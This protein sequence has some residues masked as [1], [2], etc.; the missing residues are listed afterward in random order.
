MEVPS[1]APQGTPTRPDAGGI[2]SS[3]D[4]SSLLQT[5]VDNCNALLNL[6]T[7]S[8][9]SL[10]NYHH[11]A[12]TFGRLLGALGDCVKQVRELDLGSDRTFR[13][14]VES[15][16]EY[17]LHTIDAF[18]DIISACSPSILPLAQRTD[19]F[20]CLLDR[21]ETRLHLGRVS[22]RVRKECGRKDT[23]SSQEFGC[24]LSYFWGHSFGSKTEATAAEVKR[25]LLNWLDDQTLRASLQRAS[26]LELT[27]PSQKEEFLSS[28][29]VILSGDIY[30][31]ERVF[32]IAFAD[33]L[34][35]I[36][37]QRDASALLFRAITEAR[38]HFVEECMYSS[39]Y[40][41]SDD[42]AFGPDSPYPL[43]HRAEA[44]KPGDGQ[45]ARYDSPVVIY[46][47]SKAADPTAFPCRVLPELQREMNPESSAVHTFYRYSDSSAP[48]AES[49]LTYLR[50]LKE[51]E[52]S[53]GSVQPVDDTGTQP[54]SRGNR[55]SHLEIGKE[56]DTAVNGI[57]ENAPL[58]R[59]A[60][61]AV[62]TAFTPNIYLVEQL[63]FFQPSILASMG[64]GID[65]LPVPPLGVELVTLAALAVHSFIASTSS[66]MQEL[67]DSGS[68]SPEILAKASVVIATGKGLA[69]GLFGMPAKMA[70]QGTASI[71][72]TTG[73]SNGKG[74][75]SPLQSE[76]PSS[77][78]LDSRW[79]GVEKFTR[80][81]LLRSI[82]ELSTRPEG[83]SIPGSDLRPQGAGPKT[84]KKRPAAVDIYIQTATQSGV[85][86]TP[87]S[88]ARF[89]GAFLPSDGRARDVS[90]TALKTANASHAVVSRYIEREAKRRVLQE[91][92]Q[93]TGA[94]SRSA[95]MKLIRYVKNFS[96]T[97]VAQCTT[98]LKAMNPLFAEK[99][100]E[101]AA[102]A[103]FQAVEVP[104]G[105]EF[106]TSAE[107][108][109]GGPGGT[110]DRRGGESQ[111]DGLLHL[112]TLQSKLV[113]LYCNAAFLCYS[114]TDVKLSEF[115]GAVCPMGGFSCRLAI[116]MLSNAQQQWEA[117]DPFGGA[118]FQG[119]IDALADLVAAK[120]GHGSP[121]LD[122]ALACR[123]LPL[124]PQEDVRAAGRG[125]KT[126]RSWDRYADKQTN[127]LYGLK[128]GPHGLDERG[129]P[130]YYLPGKR[131]GLTQRH[132]RYLYHFAG[133]LP[134]RFYALPL[135]TVCSS[136]SASVLAALQGVLSV[137]RFIPF[138]RS[139]VAEIA[140]YAAL[141]VMGAPA[142]LSSLLALSE[143]RAM[144]ASQGKGQTGAW[145]GSGLVYT[146][147][148]EQLAR[149]AIQSAPVGGSG[150]IPGASPDATP[151][152][153]PPAVLMQA[154]FRVAVVGT[155]GAGATTLCRFLTLAPLLTSA[156]PLAAAA[157]DPNP[158]SLPA[159]LYSQPGV[160]RTPWTLPAPQET[161]QANGT[162]RRPGQAGQA[163]ST[164]R[165]SIGSWVSFDNDRPSPRREKVTGGSQG[166][167]TGPGREGDDRTEE[168]AKKDPRKGDEAMLNLMGRIVSA[169]TESGGA[170]SQ[171]QHAQTYADRGILSS[172]PLLPD[173]ELP[174]ITP[175]F[176]DIRR[177]REVFEL[178]RNG[179]VVWDSNGLNSD[180]LLAEGDTA[181]P[182]SDLLSL[183][184]QGVAT[185]AA[186][187]TG[188]AVSMH[189]AVNPQKLLSVYGPAAPLCSSI[190]VN[191]LG[192]E[193][194]PGNIPQLTEFPPMRCIDDISNFPKSLYAAIGV[195]MEAAARGLTGAG[196]K[197]LH[198]PTGL[199]TS[200]DYDHLRTQLEARPRK[201]IPPIKFV[202]FPWSPTLVPTTY[203]IPL[204]P[205]YD[206]GVMELT[207]TPLACIGLDQGPRYPSKHQAKAQKELGSDSLAG[208]HSSAVT[209]VDSPIPGKGQQN[210]D[211]AK[212]AGSENTLAEKKAQYDQRKASYVASQQSLIVNIQS[213][214]RYFQQQTIPPQYADEQ[215][216]LVS[217]M[218]DPSTRQLNSQIAAQLLDLVKRRAMAIYKEVE[219]A[220][221]TL[222]SY[223]EK[224]KSLRAIA[225]G[226]DP[227]A[228][229]NAATA[230]RQYEEAA[231]NLRKGAETYGALY[232]V[233]LEESKTLEAILT[234]YASQQTIYKEMNSLSHEIADLERNCL[235]ATTDE[236]KE[237]AG[238]S[239][240]EPLLSNDY[241][242]VV[243][244]YD[245]SAGL[246]QFGRDVPAVCHKK[247]MASGFNVL[248]ISL[249]LEDV[250]DDEIRSTHLYSRFAACD[251]PGI[252]VGNKLDLIGLHT[253]PASAL[254]AQRLASLKHWKHVLVSTRTGAFMNSVLRPGLLAMH[255]AVSWALRSLPLQN[256]YQR[257]GEKSKGDGVRSQ[258]PLNSL[259]GP[260]VEALAGKPHQ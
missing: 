121:A 224:L 116:A 4:I 258:P 38:I 236:R 20:L 62:S 92:S 158:F 24:I 52:T 23:L 117:V 167:S 75:P 157:E 228:A 176:G 231:V 187:S 2:Q 229:A 51:R 76:R 195:E 260:I 146:P 6:I 188:S 198:L 21:C 170:G 70:V 253:D 221:N 113:A 183:F 77:S 22:C 174:G 96:Q 118:A 243:F 242:V 11:V 199:D 45:I 89:F 33:R 152:M 256:I 110:E 82:V 215:R 43:V 94:P 162:K 225:S 219:T 216:A 1:P 122:H 91:A 12:R 37:G 209:D 115:S 104:D 156:S 101:E 175:A 241:D 154:S 50:V 18:R 222:R 107:R 168:S 159:L 149:S 29:T 56:I 81:S 120:M 245:L 137:M 67:A 239:P 57:M 90:Q 112:A 106:F 190:V 28:S 144:Q 79:A 102:E 109:G 88:I 197:R 191:R 247:A 202:P 153:A 127:L 244:V 86:G 240:T 186:E 35:A 207:D 47:A 59:N 141:Q 254:F 214:H 163:D 134:L 111:A 124:M 44:V 249:S 150:T 10:C 211:P 25:A 16:N 192:E 234:T 166:P 103:L 172:F 205:V 83:E 97:I 40:N 108:D 233:Y 184:S 61:K 171:K 250:T 208:E 133:F 161:Q 71:A 178:T 128:P 13:L 147:E 73:S 235:S 74:D 64:A 251:K 55:A 148:F 98:L 139:V 200:V 69:S 27:D 140:E 155:P 48:N 193:R 230:Y 105:I 210:G 226:A 36:S 41:V 53:L 60:C 142:V 185:G 160:K 99:P 125:G 78:R 255:P 145:A 164:E 85:L 177:G 19:H 9:L 42:L 217:R 220:G 131:A 87:E 95:L 259:P 31:L 238:Q 84:P 46:S 204:L 34:H 93:Q 80:L 130:L 143:L 135:L 14:T 49:L 203:T 213:I 63:G 212:A 180:R 65:G 126:D 119:G 132:P 15:T 252:V 179:A 5:T 218:V 194:G 138:P 223:A 151:A 237:A 66:L 68:L 173:M 227:T 232:K 30:C 39:L 32:D 114:P 123:G 248:N 7:T 26:E 3:T 189:E 100:T 169:G 196:R 257:K 165:L 54:D 246:E 181:P 129:R 182:S 201:R 58:L 8:L 17:A 136:L 206:S 72:S